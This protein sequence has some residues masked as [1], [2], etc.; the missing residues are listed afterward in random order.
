MERT[1]ETRRNGVVGMDAVTGCETKVMGASTDADGSS[2]GCDVSEMRD[3]M[4]RL[5]SS[6]VVVR[7][8]LIA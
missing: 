1:R 7:R 8:E 4:S 5:R 6:W 3:E 2:E